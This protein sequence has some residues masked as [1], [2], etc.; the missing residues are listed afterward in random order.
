MR[1]KNATNH[2]FTC[3]AC[4]AV[5]LPAAVTARNHCPHCFVSVHVDGDTP[6]D[7][8]HPC[9]G[10]MRVIA[11]QHKREYWS[12]VHRCERCHK[13]QPNRTAPDDDIDALIALS[14]A[15]ATQPFHS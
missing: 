14:G 11:I 4:G 10:L 1:A 2:G 8:S 9:G 3:V 13:E 6:G 12:V 15:L 5:V 7:R